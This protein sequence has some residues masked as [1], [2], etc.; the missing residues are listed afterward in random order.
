IAEFSELGDYLKMPVR[1]YSAGMQLR[2]AFAIATL[3]KPDIFLLDE[4]IGVGDANFF[5]KAFARLEALVRRSRILF[6]A[7]HT[8]PIIQRI[9]N[10]A[11][12]L[13]NGT[14]VAYGEV[15][16]VLEAYS[17]GDARLAQVAAA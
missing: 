9:C 16:E 6:V 14:L 4:I 15:G 7:S 11:I 17:S 8:K 1:T 5:Q 3:R 13:H 2:L 12:W 10:K